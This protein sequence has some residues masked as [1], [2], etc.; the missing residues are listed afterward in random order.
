MDKKTIKNN[1]II[2]I[3]GII[4]LSFAACGKKDSDLIEIQEPLYDTAEEI[5]SD[6]DEEKENDKQK[7]V[8]KEVEEYIYVHVCGAV[9]SPG[10]Y[11][12][13]IPVRVY[14]AIE[15]AGGITDEGC[16]EVINQAREIVDGEQ[17]YIPTFEEKEN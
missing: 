14:E 4:C 3:L 16:D 5:S 1:L 13:K 7:I 11:K 6:S 8:T 2:I 10:V 9:N 17:I 12:L 15:S